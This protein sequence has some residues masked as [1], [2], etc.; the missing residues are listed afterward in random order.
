VRGRLVDLL[1]TAALPGNSEEER[2]AMCSVVVVGGWGSHSFPFPLNLSLLC[3]KLKLILSPMQLKFTRG[4][5]PKVLK[6]SSDGSDVFPKVLKLSFEGSKCKPLVGGGPI[7]V[8]IA[9]EIH[10]FLHQDV[11]KVHPA[12]NSQKYPSKKFFAVLQG[13]SN[14][15]RQFLRNRRWN[16]HIVPLHGN[17]DRLFTQGR[18]FAHR[19]PPCE[20][21]WKT[22]KYPPSFIVLHVTRLIFWAIS[23]GP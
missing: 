7:G 8:S 4:R 16:R 10:D 17:S 22:A 12:R 21:P 5:G 15:G 6:L 3:R 11:V 18:T 19:R 9:A 13:T 1:E 20:V 23:V 14:G 2:R